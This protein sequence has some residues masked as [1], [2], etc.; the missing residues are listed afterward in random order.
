M[1]LITN[2]SLSLWKESSFCRSQNILSFHSYQIH[3][4]SHW[5]HIIGN[6][7]IKWSVTKLTCLFIIPSFHIHLLSK[8]HNNSII[9]ITSFFALGTN[10]I[11]HIKRTSYHDTTDIQCIIDCLNGTNSNR[12]I[13]RIP[14]TSLY[15]LPLIS[16]ST[17]IIHF[18]TSTILLGI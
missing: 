1:F 4:I 18:E 6:N 14:V 7:N 12:S 9:W 10:H 13:V 16:G 8:S 17:W 11:V 15:K 3:H 2:N 5:T